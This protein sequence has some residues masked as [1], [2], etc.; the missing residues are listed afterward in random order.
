MVLLSEFL[1][2]EFGCRDYRNAYL[3]T[4]VCLSKMKIKRMVKRLFAVG[5]GATMLGATAMGALAADLSNYPDM[6]VTDGTFNGFF[7][8]GEA[9]ASVDNLAMTDI[10]AS[11]K[12]SKPT[13]SAST[14]TVEGDAWL[15]GTSSKKYELANNNASD[16]TVI[17][18]NIRD[19]ATFIGDD[20]LQALADSSWATNEQSHDYQ[21]FFFFDDASNTNGIVKYTESDADVTADHFFFASAREIG[22]Y[23]IE[24]SST[25]QSDVTDSTGAADTTGTYLDD[26][27]DTTLNILGKTYTVVQAR[28]PASARQTSIRLVLMAGSTSDTLLE[29][30]S[31]TYTTGGK[32]YEV[33]LSFV[34]SD[35]AKF[36]VNGETT[37]LIRDGDTYKLND[38]T[39]IGVSEILY[40]DYAGGVHS[41]TFFLGAQKLEFRDNN[42]STATSAAESTHDMI[43]GSEAQDGFAVGFTGS[44]DNTTFSVTTIE[45]NVTAEDDFFIPE[46]G[47]LSDVMTAAGEETGFFG[48][49]IDF[50]YKGLTEEETHDIQLKTSSSRRYELAL[51]DGDGNKVDIPIAYAE[52]QYNLTFGRES[53]SASNPTRTNQKRLIIQ[54]NNS[55]SKDD[56]FI[57]T[58]TTSGSA[59]DGSAKSYLLTYQ[60]SDRSTKDSPKIRFKNQGSGETLEYSVGTTNATAT[61]KLGGYSFGVYGQGI[62]ADDFPIFVALN[63]DSDI[64]DLAPV[65]FIDS[66]GSQWAFTDNSTEIF[67]NGSERP[68]NVS[69]QDSI[70]VTQSTPNVDDYDNFPPSNIV[71]NIT[72]TSGPEVLAAISGVTL[73]TPDGKTEVSY[74]YTSMGSY[75]DFREPSGDPDE[76]V[77]TYPEKQ[78][79]PQ[80][81]VT[82]GATT[83]S[84]SGSSEMASVTVVDATKLDSEIGSVSAQNLVVVGGPCVNTVAAE[85]LGNPAE[86]TQGFTPGKARVKLF[87]Q[88][89][90]NVAMLVAGYSGADTRLAGKV[91][92]HRA[93]ELS[94]SEVEVEGTTYSDATIS[95]PSAAG[96]MEETESSE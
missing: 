27:E 4:E 1:Y 13:S 71:L 32:E 89:N 60:G 68:A 36:I 2:D 9:A 17:G 3:N 7:V 70:T 12:Y 14:V 74:G 55:I 79:L 94:G 38:G 30:E 90:G 10:A 8:V 86:C 88:A 59:A 75:V 23:V 44:D 42:A 50:E 58:D 25:A 65:N 87:E 16:T 45:V 77:L 51:F 39:E 35:Q 33:T 19:I 41:S 66:Y 29:G 62:T 67:L 46:G 54:E 76:L 37:N 6:F 61:I 40:Q 81:Y 80:V 84:T 73:L 28:R 69:N 47:K 95:A 64:T 83:S 24:F 18:E 5:A 21:Q 56:Y 57:V 43:L 34:D 48:S 72:A 22:R 96:S 52:A 15:V 11:M 91:I 63:G 92:A 26:F 49:L 78:R 93:S 31:K 85:L 20:E 53:I 82:S